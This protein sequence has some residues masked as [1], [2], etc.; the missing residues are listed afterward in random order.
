VSLPLGAI[1]AFAGAGPPVQDFIRT[2]ADSANR[3]ALDS[4]SI[5]RIE[6]F[7]YDWSINAVGAPTK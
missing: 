1:V 3:Q 2:Y 5:R 6:L 4:L 7:E